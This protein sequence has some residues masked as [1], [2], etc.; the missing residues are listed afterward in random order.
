MASTKLIPETRRNP[1]TTVLGAFPND[2]VRRQAIHQG[3]CWTLAYVFSKLHST[4]IGALF[5]LYIH[6]SLP[7]RGLPQRRPYNWGLNAISGNEQFDEL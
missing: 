4:D 6:W 3:P 2:S 7:K 5:F 1:F